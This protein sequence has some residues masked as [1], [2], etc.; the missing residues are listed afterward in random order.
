MG[1]EQS[2]VVL[3]HPNCSRG[4][5]QDTGKLRGPWWREAVPRPVSA[6]ELGLSGCDAPLPAGGTLS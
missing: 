2:P 4:G 5:P 6:E 1:Y 3:E